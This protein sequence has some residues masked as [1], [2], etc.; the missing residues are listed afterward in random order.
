MDKESAEGQARQPQKRSNTGAVQVW[1]PRLCWKTPL[2][3]RR[4]CVR[5]CAQTRGGKQAV[6]PT[7]SFCEATCAVRG[8]PRREC[9]LWEDVQE[10]LDST[11]SAF[12]RQSRG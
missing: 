9:V 11:S 2:H 3:G 7:S 10:V 12:A 1:M 4:G 5:R 6:E 8:Q